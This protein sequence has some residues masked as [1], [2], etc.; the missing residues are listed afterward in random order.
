[1]SEVTKNTLASYHLKIDVTNLNTYTSSK[2]EIGPG[3]L[4]WGYIEQLKLT[5]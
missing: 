2:F 4:T 5:K 1:M 3:L